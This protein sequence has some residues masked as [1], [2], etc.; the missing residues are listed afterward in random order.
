MSPDTLATRQERY[1]VKKL[2]QG[3]GI[4]QRCRRREGRSHDYKDT[5]AL[6]ECGKRRLA[7]H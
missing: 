6:A 2:D 1:R 3:K 4:C 7:L 5:L